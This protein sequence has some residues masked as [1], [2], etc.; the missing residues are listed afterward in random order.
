PP[1]RSS[2]L[3]RQGAAFFGGHGAVVG[4]SLSIRDGQAGVLSDGQGF[5][6]TDL[7][8]LLQGHIAVHGAALAVKDDTSVA[9]AACTNLNNRFL[10]VSQY[11]TVS[12]IHH[13][14]AA[15][16]QAGS[17]TS[18]VRVSPALG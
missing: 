9:I 5:V 4:Q 1:R 8:V 3:S 2:D 13:C 16:G 10:I 12:C 7:Q 11:S 6:I 15:D 14:V 17:A 18:V